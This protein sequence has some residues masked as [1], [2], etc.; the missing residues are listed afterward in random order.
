MARA[1]FNIAHHFIRKIFM[2]DSEPKPEM[3]NKPRCGVCKYYT[4]V[5]FKDLTQGECRRFPP[6]HFLMVDGR[7]MASVSGFSTTRNS[8]WCGEY[9]AKISLMS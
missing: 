4:I 6:G 5:E 3:D 8:N 9:Q 7:G 1:N 2:T